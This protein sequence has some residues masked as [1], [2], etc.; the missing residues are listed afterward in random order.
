MNKNPVD[1][2]IKDFQVD[3]QIR[4]ELLRNTI[5]DAASEAEEVISYKMP[6][7][8]LNGILVYFSGFKN[9]IGFYALPTGHENFKSE[10]SAFKTGK[11]SVQFPNDK[12][13][14]IELI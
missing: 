6:A 4:L 9:H 3:I 10:L 8:K 1:K 11:G 12:E 14:P 5:R 7:Y 13:L 2:Y